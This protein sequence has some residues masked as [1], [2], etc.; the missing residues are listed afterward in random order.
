[1]ITATAEAVHL[2]KSTQVWEIKI[3]DET[4]KLICISRCT[5][6]VKKKRK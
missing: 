1:L 3:T 2:G 6:A 5:I 4:D